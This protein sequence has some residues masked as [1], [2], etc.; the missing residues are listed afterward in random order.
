MRLKNLFLCFKVLKRVEGVE[1]HLVGAQYHQRCFSSFCLPTRP[2]GASSGRPTEPHVSSS[3][4]RI[5]EYLEENKDQCQFSLRELSSLVDDPPSDST[6]KAKLQ[7]KYKEDIV[8]TSLVGRTPIICFRNHAVLLE[9]W[10]Q[11]RKQNEGD[12]RSRIV[13]AAAAII[14]EDIR[15][16]IYDTDYYPSPD[17]FLDD[18]EKDVPD[19]LQLFL[20]EI[21]L[22]TKR[23]SRDK[24]LKKCTSIAH[25]IIAAAR[26]K[27]FVSSLQVGLAAYLHSRFGSKNLVNVVSAL[28]F[29][30]SYTEAEIFQISAILHPE[31]Q[32]GQGFIQFVADNAD[33]NVNTLD[34]LG[35]FHS[36]G[37]I[38]CV[39]P[40]ANNRTS[41]GLFRVT[42]VPSAA[43]LGNFGHITVETF[44]RKTA[45]SELHTLTV[46]KVNNIDPI[47]PRASDLLWMYGKLNDVPGICGWNGFMEQITS[48]GTFSTSDINTMSFINASPSDYNTIYTTLLCAVAECEKVRPT[49]CFIT[50]DQPLYQK[51]RDIISSTSDPRL[52]S[53]V[54]RL[55]GFHLL[56]SFL[57][58][59]GYVMSG[60]GLKELLSTIYAP[61]SV[62]KMLAGHAYSRAVRGHLLTHLTLGQIIL[63]LVEFSDE[64]RIEIEDVLTDCCD[65]SGELK[66]E[67]EFFQSMSR[68]FEAQLKELEKN[69]PTAKLWVLY[70]RMVTLVKN[71]IEAERTG[72]WKLHLST[73][74]KMMPFF[75]ATGHFNYALSAQLYLQDMHELQGS[76]SPRD[77]RRFVGAGFFTIRRS[78]KY[79]SGIWSDMTIEQTLMRGMKT[80]GGLTGG[81]GYTDSVLAKWTKGLPVMQKVSQSMEEFV[82]VMSSTSEQ[83]VDSRPSRQERDNADVAKLE[84]WFSSHPPFP[85]LNAI[86]SLG[87][88]IVGGPEINC[89]D[90]EKVGLDRIDA[91][92]GQSFDKISFSRKKRVLPL[93]AVSSSIKIGDDVIAID[94]TL[95]Y[96]RISFAK[97]SQD[98]LKKYFAYELSP[99]PLSLFDE[100]GMRKSK[101][102]AMYDIFSP[103]EEATFSDDVG[104]I[105]DGGFLLHKVVWRKGAY[106]SFICQQYVDYV[107][108]HYKGEVTIVFDGYSEDAVE[109]STKTAERLRRSTKS[110]ATETLFDET[111]QVTVA[112]DKFLGNDKNKSRLIEVLK[113]KFQ[114]AGYIVKQHEGDADTLIVTT[115][116]ELSGLHESIIIVGEDVDLLIILTGIAKE[117]ERNVY[118]M[119]PG[120]GKSPKLVYSANSLKDPTLARH[121]LFYHAFTGCDT[122]SAIFNQ[123]KLKVTTLSKK[124]EN[125]EIAIDTF[126]NRNSD[127]DSIDAAGEKVLV[128]LYGGKTEDSLN[129]LRYDGFSRSIT[130]SKFNLASLPPT[131]AAARQ[132]S[133]RTFHQVQHWMGNDLQAESWGWKHG[134]QGLTPILTLQDPAPKEL[135]EFVQCRCAKGCGARCGCKK[136]GLNCSEACHFCHG[137]SCANAIKVDLTQSDDEVEE[138]TSVEQ[139][140]AQSDRVGQPLDTFLDYESSDVR[141]DAE[142]GALD[143]TIVECEMSSE[144]TT[145]LE[146]HYGDP[147]PSHTKKFKCS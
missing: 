61:L 104:Y 53:V 29:C 12:E 10:Y 33:V 75:H 99:Y 87:T 67:N 59:I 124:F 40:K 76:I 78:E 103:V 119:K 1:L 123:G 94:P 91:I 110:V 90:A 45:P 129:K 48:K 23:K 35:T 2:S 51:A 96:Q 138:P 22:K 9:S 132:H 147:G 79:R 27:S 72:N 101:K 36:M 60:S 139:W 18:A 109:K 111:M 86:V 117:T 28:G 112:Q 26:P 126:V 11:N 108:K 25:S 73:I 68:R 136:A 145:E 97:Q 135:L 98:D 134:S 58:A 66:L 57:G 89:F 55:G 70:F 82:D 131:K 21:I 83:H 34:G 113:R 74:A 71:F 8:I 140:C 56:M 47:S 143:N 4:A 92:V 125:L 144:C 7:E 50:F 122:T 19:T 64:E 120:K 65:G 41:R 44:E 84:K 52:Q 20:K 62:E 146:E 54:V 5:F 114:V 49:T 102:S 24:Y 105:I 42:D 38:N 85:V 115:A 133:L 46:Q 100:V 80:K 6:L 81:R 32:A 17:T 130:K 3:M 30:A 15:S 13:R 106:F 31:A 93:S 118:F 77:Y 37:M 95:L 141:S 14:S 121:I 116:L 127:P 128:A 16:Q 63:K 43:V 142:D 137:Q 39:T 107:K 69:G 88:G